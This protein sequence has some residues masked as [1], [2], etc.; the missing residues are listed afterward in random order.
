MHETAI[1]KY[2]QRRIK[3]KSNFI[4]LF[5]MPRNMLLISFN[6]WKSDPVVSALRER[7]RSFDAACS[8]GV[9]QVLRVPQLKEQEL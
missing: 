5:T 8:D 7:I 1:L 2:G 4:F 9:S 6:E 3:T